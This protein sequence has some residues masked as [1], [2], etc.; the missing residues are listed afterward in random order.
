M[1]GE[2]LGASYPKIFNLEAW[3]GL[4]RLGK[5]RRSLGGSGGSKGVRRDQEE[6]SKG[7]KCEVNGLYS[8]MEKT[9]LVQRY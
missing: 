9:V 7:V 3:L 8:Q 2:A 6:V 1:P 4:E 5:I